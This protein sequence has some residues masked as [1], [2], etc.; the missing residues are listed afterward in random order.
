ME[1]ANFRHLR[2]GA[3]Y[4]QETPTPSEPGRGAGIPALPWNPTLGEGGGLLIYSVPANNGLEPLK[5]RGDRYGN[6][7]QTANRESAALNWGL[8]PPIGLHWSTV[9]VANNKYL[10]SN[11]CGNS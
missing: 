9:P 3:P 8:D 5:F 10:N 2:R 11:G 6:P 1:V 4:S 7:N